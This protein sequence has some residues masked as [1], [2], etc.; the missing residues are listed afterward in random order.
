M[1]WALGLTKRTQ[2]LFIP[3]LSLVLCKIPEQL[4]EGFC[5]RSHQHRLIT[6]TDQTSAVVRSKFLQTKEHGA[7]TSVT[8]AASHRT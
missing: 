2:E 8:K 7:D 3:K 4:D 6:V 1:R 5:R